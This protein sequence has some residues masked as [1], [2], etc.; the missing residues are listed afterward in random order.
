MESHP[1]AAHRLRGPAALIEAARAG[2]PGQPP[3]RPREL[4]S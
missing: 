2:P 3:E 1:V 4:V